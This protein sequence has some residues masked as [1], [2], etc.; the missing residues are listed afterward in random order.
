M[1]VWQTHEKWL[2]MCSSCWLLPHHGCDVISAFW[3]NQRILKIYKKMKHLILLWFSC[4]SLPR[5]MFVMW[6]DKVCKTIRNSSW[7]YHSSRVPVSWLWCDLYFFAKSRKAIILQENET[8]DI[9]VVFVCF[10]PP[11]HGYDV[12]SQIW[13]NTTNH[14]KYHPMLCLLCS[15]LFRIMVLIWFGNFGKEREPCKTTHRG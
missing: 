4:V 5:I 2:L 3:Q 9:I 11:H 1:Q 14:C 12:I 6:L 7:Y 10:A 15:S 13:Q 8:C